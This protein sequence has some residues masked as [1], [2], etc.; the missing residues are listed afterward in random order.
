MKTI[1]VVF[2][3]DPP[4]VTSPSLVEDFTTSTIPPPSFQVCHRAQVL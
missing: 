3:C 4:S 1:E 2:V